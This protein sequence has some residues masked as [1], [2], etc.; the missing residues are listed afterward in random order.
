MSDK[1]SDPTQLLKPLTESIKFTRG[2]KFQNLDEAAKISSAMRK[3]GSGEEKIFDITV[4][5]DPA[6]RPKLSETIYLG[7]LT[8]E[9]KLFAKDFQISR[10][11]QNMKTM[12]PGTERHILFSD[13]MGPFLDFDPPPPP[14]DKPTR[15][16]DD[17]EDEIGIDGG[18]TA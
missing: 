5:P 3:L 2:S 18:M 14:P 16:Y 7:G 6:D 13:K 10:A 12:K 11:I 15:R 17:D 8:E 1:A 4:H 9:G